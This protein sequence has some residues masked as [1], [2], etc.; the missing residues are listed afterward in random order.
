M[1]NNNDNNDHNNHNNHNDNNDNDKSDSDSDSDI[2]YD[3][4]TPCYLFREV[5]YT[6]QQVHNDCDHYRYKDE[7]VRLHCQLDHRFDVEL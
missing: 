6:A 2:D 5:R 4:D 3:N 7:E 1:N